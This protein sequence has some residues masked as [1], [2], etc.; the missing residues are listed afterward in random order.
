MVGGWHCSYSTTSIPEVTFCQGQD[1]LQWCVKPAVPLPQCASF[2]FK[3]HLMF[4][5]MLTSWLSKTL[6][7]SLDWKLPPL[8]CQQMLLDYFAG[9]AVIL[10]YIE[11]EQKRRH[12]VGNWTK[13]TKLLNRK[14]LYKHLD[15]IKE[16]DDIFFSFCQQSQWKDNSQQ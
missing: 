6:V 8:L 12:V 2:H 11:L 15:Q 3:A 5:L 10:E 16:S 14:C 7:L 9:A 1:C 4:T 13:S